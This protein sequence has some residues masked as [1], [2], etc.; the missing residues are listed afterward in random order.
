M[1]R[2]SKREQRKFV[3]AGAR[4]RRAPA[5]PR[6]R[7]WEQLKDIL[8]KAFR[9]RL[10]KSEYGGVVD[11]SHGVG[12]NVHIVVISRLFDKMNDKQRQEWMW[13]IVDDTDLTDEEKQLISLIYP[14]SPAEIK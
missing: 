2:I 9:E 12:P 5:R 14:V 11:I 10:E 1:V 13:I 8:E 6:R 4:P 7:T 3:L